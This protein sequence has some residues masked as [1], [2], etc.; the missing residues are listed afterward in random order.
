MRR[1]TAGSL[2]SPSSTSRDRVAAPAASRACSRSRST[3]A[4][5]RTGASTSTTLTDDGDIRIDQFARA[6]RSRDAP[7]RARPQGHRRSPTRAS[8]T[9]TAASSQFGPD[10]HPLH[11]HRRRRL[12]RR[13][14][15]ERPE[16]RPLLGKML[17][18]D[19]QARKRRLHRSRRTTRSSA[20]PGRRDLRARPAQPVPVL[21]RPQTGDL[22][23]G[24]VGQDARGDRLREPARARGANFGWD[25]FEGDATVRPDRRRRPTPTPPPADLHRTRAAPARGAARSSAAT[26]SATPRSPPHRAVHLHRPLRGEIHS[27]DPAAGGASGDAARAAP[28]PSS[29]ARR[30]PASTSPRW[31]G[32][33]YRLDPAPRSRRVRRG[34][35]L[36][37]V[38]VARAPRRAPPRPGRAASSSSE[39]GS[40][41]QPVY[42]DR[43]RLRRARCS[44][45]SSAGRIGLRS[46]AA[47]LAGPFLDIA[48]RVTDA[49]EGGLLVGRLPPRLHRKP[50]LLRLLHR[51]RR[52]HRRRRVQAPARN[53]TRPSGSRAQGD[54]DPPPELTRTTTADSSQFGPDGYST[55]HRRRR[56]RRRPARQRP[57]PRRAAR[58]DPPH[59]PARSG[60]R[61]TRSPKAI[62]SSAQRPRR[63]LRARACATPSASRSTA[64][65]RIVIGDVGQNRGRRSTPDAG[66]RQRRQL[67][68]GRVRGL[69]PFECDGARPRQSRATGPEFSHEGG[70]C[71]VTG[72]YVVHDPRRRRSTGATSTPT[73]AGARSAASPRASAGSRRTPRIGVSVQSPT[74][75]FGEDNRG[76]LYVASLA[77]RVSRLA[78]G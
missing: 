49:G 47:T 25:A 34:W 73:S 59:R 68:L 13:P 18:I 19:P 44:S 10:G 53:P 78:P 60:G 32:P 41:N 69:S 15:R 35:P 29:S 17:R 48:D 62:R 28:A 26:S 6:P 56:R 66:G 51:Q 30:R 74:S 65:G 76:R 11:R 21:V 57:E 67:R 36:A 39:I 43:A 31:Q 75:G 64:G 63:D 42:V 3:P 9:T 2:R 77:G 46:R 61:P 27:F 54:R 1:A 14:D 8:P 45:S 40:F 16:P 50:P 7:S 33:V 23:I 55:R 38:A 24:D 58:Q 70:N 4:T 72:G 22:A 20:R 52:R 5:R 71:S 37:V 12:R